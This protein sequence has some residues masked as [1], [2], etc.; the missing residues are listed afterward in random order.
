M[1][2][3][4]VKYYHSIP[5]RNLFFKRFY[6]STQRGANVEVGRE[7]IL[8]NDPCLKSCMKWASSNEEKKE[9]ELKLYFKIESGQKHYI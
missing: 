4:K 1:S 8:C 3:Q 9:V 6:L 5:T 7:V 2:P